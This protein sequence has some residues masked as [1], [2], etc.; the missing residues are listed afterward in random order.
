MREAGLR[1]LLQLLAHLHSLRIN[2]SQSTVCLIRMLDVCRL[3]PVAGRAETRS[4]D[5]EQT[6][7][8]DED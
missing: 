7:V 2:T 8:I 1:R 3:R 5:Y 6:F 4:A